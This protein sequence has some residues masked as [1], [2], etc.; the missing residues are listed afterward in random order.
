MERNLRRQKNTKYPGKPTT[1]SQIKECY[2][3]RVTKLDFGLNL[4]KTEPFYI[5][6]IESDVN[7]AFT[8]FASY[9]VMGLIEKHIPPKDRRYLIDGTFDACPIGCYYQLLIIV[10]EFKNDVSLKSVI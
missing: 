8:L 9:H 6:T 1:P 10:I 7:S 3:N 5:D 4:A 2:E